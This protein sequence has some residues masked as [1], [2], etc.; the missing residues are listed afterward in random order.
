MKK[1]VRNRFGI[2]LGENKMRF[3]TLALG[4]WVFMLIL[5]MVNSLGIFQYQMPT[6]NFDTSSSDA[7]ITQL[8][9]TMSQNQDTGTFG[10]IVAGVG[11]ITGSFMYLIDVFWKSIN[12]IGLGNAYGIDIRISAP[13]QALYTFTLVFGIYQF[14]TG[15]AVKIM[16]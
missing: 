2:H 1:Q 15:R 4:I 12:L 3:Y 10:S 11:L 7:Q 8:T 9:N 6:A 16:E 13:F 14:L 5:S